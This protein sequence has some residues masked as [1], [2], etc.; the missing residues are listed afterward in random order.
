M[1]ELSLHILDLAQNSIAAGAALVELTVAEDTAA[2]TLT[3]A[4]GD[5]GRGMTSEQL[6]EVSDPFY[7]TRT[8]RKVGLGVPLFKMAAEQAGGRFSI[9]S[10]AGKGTRVEGVFGLSN[11]DRMP[12]GDMAGTVS[13][14]IAGS[15]DRDFLYRRT[16][17]GE[18]FALDTR[19]LRKTLGDVPLSNG[20]VAVW[21]RE[22]LEENEK[23]L[24]SAGGE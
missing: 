2:D 20:E 6:R 12:L 3:I 5:N 13:A 11:I 15:P 17:D 9:R 16:R 14:L 24:R 19:E 23:A 22:Y 8:T 18:G 21:I 1:Q 4:I 10:Q 7:T